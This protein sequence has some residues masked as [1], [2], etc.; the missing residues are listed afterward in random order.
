[1]MLAYGSYRI[2]SARVRPVRLPLLLF[3]A[4]LA[5]SHHQTSEHTA[6][7]SG[8]K[9]L[10]LDHRVS[11]S[12][13]GW[14]WRDGP[15][16]DLFRFVAPA[17]ASYRFDISGG[18]EHQASIEVYSEDSTHRRATLGQ[19]MDSL[20][21][22][23]PPGTYYVN[24]D[25]NRVDRG[26]YTLSVT[27]DRSYR[28]A[29]RPEAPNVV[30]PLCERAPTLGAEATLG[31]FESRSG[32]ASTSCGGVGGDTVYAVELRARSVITLDAAAQFEFALEVRDSC[33]GHKQSK[34]CIKSTAYEA[35]ASVAVDPGRYIVVL[36]SVEIGSLKTGLPGAAIRGAYSLQARAVP[37]SGG[38]Q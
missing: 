17:A 33:L 7:L 6:S 18:D 19:T 1:M 27:V 36:D 24:V 9:A 16:G 26:A 2:I 23:L 34:L 11:G 10:L 15:G 37:E 32:G 8:A 13:A 21:L 38:G 29:I 22:P 3:P 12:T 20:S 25:D 28:A 30:E 4:L 35:H 5:C 14:D 31:T